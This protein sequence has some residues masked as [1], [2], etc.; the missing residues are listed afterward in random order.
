M[1]DINIKI[2]L[3]NNLLP[4][5]ALM[6][7]SDEINSQIVNILRPIITHERVVECILEIPQQNLKTILLKLFWNNRSDHQ[8]TNNTYLEI[9]ANLLSFPGISHI[10]MTTIFD[11][12]ERLFNGT[13]DFYI[14]AEAAD[15]TNRFNPSRGHI[16]L[17]KLRSENPWKNVYLKFQTKTQQNSEDLL[18]MIRH[19]TMMRN[20]VDEKGIAHVIYNDQQNVHN[21]MINK[22]VITAA[23]ALIKEMVPVIKFND[24]Y[25]IIAFKD[26]TLE[27]VTKKL[28]GILGK[29]PNDIKIKESQLQ[30]QMNFEII[31]KD[32][33]PSDDFYILE[34]VNLYS[35][36]I[37]LDDY[38][39][40]SDIER[41]EISGKILEQLFITTNNFFKNIPPENVNDLIY[42]L[43]L[44]NIPDAIDIWFNR[45]KIISELYSLFIQ[46]H[47]K[48]KNG[49]ITKV[50]KQLFSNKEDVK[51][52]KK[53][54]LTGTVRDISL[55]DLLNA[56]WKFI[57]TQKDHV[58]TLKQR[59]KEELL[60][61]QGVCMTGLCA[62]LVS[63]IQGYFDEKKY[64]L[65]KIK[66]SVKDEFKAQLTNNI[67]KLAI[68]KKLDPIMDKSDFK[69][70]IDDYIENNEINENN[71]NNENIQDDPEKYSDIS[72][73]M[74][75]EMAYKIYD[76]L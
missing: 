54:I 13:Q 55:F 4:H 44:T 29:Q 51:I 34:N 28:T 30:A 71:E 3:V 53:Q 35:K 40:P 5:P 64:P 8:L 49:F 75:T 36:V 7:S 52:L 9:M 17:N 21:N 20:Q 56:V 69:K 10:D 38:I 12:I 43:N 58:V 26:D 15:I 41:D 48:I 67:N 42:F 19:Q 2:S 74:M 11:E 14:R 76:I 57:H 33:T 37:Y 50:F 66:I 47:K 24:K 31:N 72:K 22:S 23:N 65:F 6:W 18:T 61:G 73:E 46:P 62:H 59:L 32:D 39:F 45:R 68:D 27:T 25:K 70:L 16:L 60:E 63:V 1:E